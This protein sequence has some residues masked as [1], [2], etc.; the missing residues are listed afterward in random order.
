MKG[1][2]SIL[3]RSEK[4]TITAIFNLSSLKKDEKEKLLN[5]YDI[6]SLVTKTDTITIEQ[7]III[8]YY[9][10][11][12]SINRLLA[13]LD[14]ASIVSVNTKELNNQK[15]LIQE[16]LCKLEQVEKRITF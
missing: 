3:E 5:S 6:R 9:N 1:G 15:C 11:I 16:L 12:S 8:E 2:I 4:L 13:L 14:C 10:I 7:P